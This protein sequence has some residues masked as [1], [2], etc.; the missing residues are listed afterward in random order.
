MEQGRWLLLL[1]ASLTCQKFV[2]LG[3]FLE[4]ILLVVI[5]HRPLLVVIRQGRD[6]LAV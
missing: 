1:L 2:S 3:C 5:L 4:A 6:C